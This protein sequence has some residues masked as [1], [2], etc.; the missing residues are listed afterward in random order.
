MEQRPSR[1]RFVR[2][3]GAVGLTLTGAGCLGESGSGDGSSGTPT[4]ESTS[5]PT[6]TPPETET[7][8]ATPEPDL[9]PPENGAVAFVY[10]D[11][12]ITDY[13]TALPVHREFDAPATTG[14]VSDF[15][16]RKYYMGVE[17]LTAL[18]DAGWEIASHTVSHTPVGTYELTRP[19][20][21]DATELYA[22]GIRHGHHEGST[23]QITDGETTVER[24][25]EGLDRDE[26]DERHI[27]LAEPVGESFSKGALLRYP[28]EFVER[29]LA[30]S[31]R[32]LESM[33]FTVDSFLAPYDNFDDYSMR[34]VPEYYDYV[35]NARPGK[36]INY[37]EGF[38]P[39]ATRRD[40]YIE[41]TTFDAVEK[42]VEE[43]AATGA[44]GVFGAHTF[45]DAVTK[46]KIRQTLSSIE[47]HGIE[48][49]TLREA[50]ERYASGGT[51]PG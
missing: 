49:M 51:T 35:A 39:Y 23:L 40:Y 33:G 27:V 18:A 1:R 29:S 30:K 21:A 26:E 38:D 16:G 45:E 11:G 22:T 7:P 10:D 19:V 48:V 31:K 47:D 12:R 41:Y 5:S 28:P 25:I 36:R 32:D 34:F 2:A 46:E 4:E 50:C 8:T 24:T 15:V 17:E 13:E 9:E 6:S 44:L 20:E 43:I 37:A 14:V 42:D 3:I